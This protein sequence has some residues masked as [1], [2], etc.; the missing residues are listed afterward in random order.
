MFLFTWLKGHWH[1]IWM[2]TE[3]NLA[4]FQYYWH[5]S[6]RSKT[7]NVKDLGETFKCKRPCKCKCLFKMK[8]KV[9]KA[10]GHSVYIYIYKCFKNVK[11]SQEAVLFFGRT[12]L[13]FFVHLF[14]FLMKTCKIGIQIYKVFAKDSCNAQKNI[15]TLA[16]ERQQK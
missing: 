5:Y 10:V 2:N 4:C 9:R 14:F 8:K 16:G 13:S 7:R 11:W 15:I 1:C 6:A 3:L 12:I